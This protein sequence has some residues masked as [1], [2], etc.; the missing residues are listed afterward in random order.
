MNNELNCLFGL[1][2]LIICFICIATLWCDSQEKHLTTFGFY[3][4]FSVGVVSLISFDYFMLQYIS[5][6]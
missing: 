1:F 3:L 4:F 6:L 5:K 2:S